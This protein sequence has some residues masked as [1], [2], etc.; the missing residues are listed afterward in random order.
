MY[1]S[2]NLWNL[3]CVNPGA[4]MNNIDTDTEEGRGTQLCG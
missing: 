3:A 1:V 4:G 2:T